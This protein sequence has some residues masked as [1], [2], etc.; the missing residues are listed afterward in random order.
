M[1]YDVEVFPLLILK[2]PPDFILYGAQSTKSFL[3]LLLM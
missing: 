2:L 3:G 1:M